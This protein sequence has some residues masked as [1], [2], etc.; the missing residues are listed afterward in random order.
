M[1]VKQRQNKIIDIIRHKKHVTV[2][3][4]ATSLDISRETIR[5]DLSDLGK[6]N[7]IQKV[8]GGATLPCIISESSFQQR[9]VKNAK[10]KARIADVASTLFLAGETL[11]IDTG[12]TTLYFAE[13]LAE[14]SGLTIITNSVEIAK[15]IAATNHHQ[16]FLLGGE[17]S[18]NNH[19][20][21][22]TMVTSQVRLFRAHHAVLTIGA[23]DERTGAMD[24]DIEEAQ[25]AH[26][27]IEQAQSLTLLV[28]SSKFNQIAS[29]EVCSYS[30]VNR[31]VCDK[32]PPKNLYDLMLA[33]GIEVIIAP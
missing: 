22:G 6:Q 32:Q 5:R 23:L 27:M 8:H 29:F 11:F 17:F 26:A 9:M 18:L 30:Q 2:E 28:D 12:S 4:L 10:G 25:V 15:T 13:K 16:T 19:Q 1:K 3:D 7:K 20:T 21:V 31:V 24:F 33:Q 14:K